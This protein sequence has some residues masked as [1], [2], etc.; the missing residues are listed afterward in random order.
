MLIEVL[1]RAGMGKKG[2]ARLAQ[3]LHLHGDLSVLKDAK[4]LV[5]DTPAEAHRR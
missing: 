4:K 3:L 1:A 2:Q 5:R